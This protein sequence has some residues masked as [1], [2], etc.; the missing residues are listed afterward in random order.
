MSRAL[1]ALDLIRAELEASSRS[2]ARYL[3]VVPASAEQL[4]KLDAIREAKR[5]TS[6]RITRLWPD[7]SW[8]KRARMLRV[9]ES[10]LRGQLDPLLLKRKPSLEVLK[11]LAAYEVIGAP[12]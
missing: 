3:A 2:R 6:E 8:R 7:L 11:L 5:E 9:D 4:S 10:T 1:E 12:V